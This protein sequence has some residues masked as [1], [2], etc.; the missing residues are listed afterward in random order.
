MFRWRLG[1][2]GVLFLFIALGVY[3]RI[4]GDPP[5][6]DSSFAERGGES[7]SPGS[8]SISDAPQLK[9]PPPLG[10][11]AAKRVNPNWDSGRRLIL[12][13][14]DGTT[15]AP[16]PDAEVRL[17]ES[18][19]QGRGAT[20]YGPAYSNARG[21]VG[22]DLPE[23]SY[24][25]TARHQRYVALQ[26]SVNLGASGSVRKRLSMLPAIG[27]AGRV[28][29]QQGRPR[30]RAAIIF[31]SGEGASV[32]VSS[33][34]DGSFQTW[35][36]PSRYRVSASAQ[37]GVETVM[38]GVDIWPGKEFFLEIELGETSPSITFSGKVEAAHGAVSDAIVQVRPERQP[39]NAGG[40][41]THRIAFHHS[42][43]TGPDGRFSLRLPPMGPALLTILAPG[44][45]TLRQR[46]NLQRSPMKT[47]RLQEERGF[48]L[49]VIDR[50]GNVVRGVEIV[51]V[52]G[53][54]RRVVR[55]KGRFVYSASEYPFEIYAVDRRSGRPVTGKEL[56]QAYQAEILLDSPGR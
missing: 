20:E 32:E 33:G 28:A 50:Q 51:G 45:E 16:I 35:L 44:H 11:R 18:D 48:H 4:T 7:S 9:E 49:K 43:A 6:D 36:Q 25:V 54:G 14:T 8:G 21:E 37:G 31:S 17:H 12:A 39:E 13:A 23:G 26:E 42:A 53:E 52:N 30:P 19:Y 2:Y 24:V 56:I 55:A 34:G 41:S 10:S 1:L 40:L 3:W 5:S 29:D 47:F 46:V 15:G 38:H 22:F 27:V